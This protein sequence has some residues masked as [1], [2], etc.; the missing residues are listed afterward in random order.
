NG[1]RCRSRAA[2]AT[3][4][5][6]KGA[7]PRRI[8]RASSMLRSLRHG[9]VAAL[10]LIVACSDDDTAQNPPVVTNVPAQELPPLEASPPQIIPADKRLD[11]ASSP[12][13]FDALRGGVWTANGDAGTVSYVDVDAGKVVK[14]IP[15][16]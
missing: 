8:P 4:V 16:G 7:T 15:I 9:L 12:V 10:A 3:Q 14:E 2:R 1:K 6:Q 13:V 5:L 11:A